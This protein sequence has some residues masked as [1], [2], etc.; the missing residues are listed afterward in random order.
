MD[1]DAANHMSA[2]LSR[3]RVGTGCEV[4][5][6]PRVRRAGTSH[7]SLA[8]IEDGDADWLGEAPARRWPTAEFHDTSHASVLRD[9]PT[10]TANRTDGHGDGTAKA[11]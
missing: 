1:G 10:A 7:E 5:G 6:E 3:H 4:K 11:K 9:R 8:R 2:R